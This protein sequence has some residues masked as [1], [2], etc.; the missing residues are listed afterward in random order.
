MRAVIRCDGSI[1]ELPEPVS[2]TQVC[3]LI[4][5]STLDTV[6]LH[7]MGQPL[8]VMMVDDIGYETK[9]IVDGNATLL[10]PMSARK[11]VN[12][13]ATALYLLNC[14]PGTTHQI[15]GDVVVVPDED[16]ADGSSTTL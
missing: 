6:A 11:P 14:R 4:G 7:H 5:A 2:I 16:F 15:V 8:H 12:A 3:E 10:V 1:E 9:S 13:Q